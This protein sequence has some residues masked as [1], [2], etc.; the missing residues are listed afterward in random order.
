MSVYRV[1]QLNLTHRQLLKSLPAL[2]RGLPTIPV[3]QIVLSR[4]RLYSIY[5]HF[6]IVLSNKAFL[7]C[8]HICTSLRHR[9]IL[10]PVSNVCKASPKSLF[11]APKGL[12]E[13]LEVRFEFPFILISK[14]TMSLLTGQSWRM[15]KSWYTVGGPEQG[16]LCCFTDRLNYSLV[17]S[18]AQA[19]FAQ[20][21]DY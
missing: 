12:N 4:Y 16:F 9:R 1:H 3:V 11:W 18:V 19:L 5:R 10:T 14:S 2:P 8:D 21:L 15:I 13:L 17:S 7:F 20:T 6:E